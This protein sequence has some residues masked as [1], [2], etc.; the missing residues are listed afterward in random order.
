M[1]NKLSLVL[2]GAVLAGGISVTALAQTPAPM[3]PGPGKTTM[4]TGAHPGM[5]GEH[6]MTGTIK[7][8]DHKTGQVELES[9]PVNLSVHFP[10]ADLKDLK[11][12]DKI[13]VHLSFS[14]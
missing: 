13:T 12:G 9:K 10:P 11:E 14:K 5:M 2:A 6:T 8:I 7:T 1:M 4:E 3:P